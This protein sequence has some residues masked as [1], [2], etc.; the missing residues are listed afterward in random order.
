MKTNNDEEKELLGHFLERTFYKDWQSEGPGG[1]YS[2]LEFHLKS[3]C[4]LNC[5]YCYYN[6]RSGNGKK[7]HSNDMADAKTL[8]KNL[9]L[10]L[11]F[12]SQNKYFPSKFE[13][14]GGEVLNQ[15]VF[16]KLIEQV[17]E[18]YKQTDKPRHIMIPTNMSFVRKPRHVERIF[19]LQERS[20]ALRSPIGLSASIDGKYMDQ[21]N[22][23]YF[24]RNKSQDYY[25]NDDFYDKVFAFAKE[26][27]LAFHPMTHY[28][29][30]ENAFKNFMWFQG[31]FKKHDIP[32]NYL[33]QLE[34]RNDGW[35]QESVKHYVQFYKQLLEFSLTMF[36]GD[37]AT[38][39][40]EFIFNKSQNFGNMNLFNNT[41]IIGRG[42]GCSMQT[43]MQ[44]RLSD[45]MVTPCHRQSYDAFNGF[46]YTHDGESITGVETNN[47]AYYLGSMSTD[48]KT[49]PYC[50]TCLIKSICM[51]GCP[52][53]QFESMGEPYLPIPSVCLVQFGK[54]KA[55]IEFLQKH[56]IFTAFLQM[57][58]TE[59]VVAYTECASQ[60]NKGDK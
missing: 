7:L 31:N 6:D 15:P 47:L 5:T 37:T 56:N 34:V 48:Q 12:L 24:S 21:I 43:T 19:K 51:G 26:Y 39:L 42:I 50:E 1:L 49:W 60:I 44:M 28:V 52:G 58:V 30:I 3:R 41:S 25:Y 54:I 45:L 22:R 23:P 36:G 17:F 38:F 29:N 33:Y 13:F 32:W 14:F 16:Y 9:E 57:L 27:G 59:Q 2:G 46:K 20:Y 8:E 4:N 11:K 40:N 18:F 35:T 10:Y 53:S 55:Q